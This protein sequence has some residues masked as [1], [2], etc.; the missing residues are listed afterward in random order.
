MNPAEKLRLDY[1]IRLREAPSNKL[2]GQYARWEASQGRVEAAC[3]I[4]ERYLDSTADPSE[5]IWLLYTELSPSHSMKLDILT[6]AIHQQPLS[7]RL[8]RS[9]LK[10]FFSPDGAPLL[11]ITNMEHLVKSWMNRVLENGS[12]GHLEALFKTLVDI[13][14]QLVYSD[15]VQ[16]Y[17]ELMLLLLHAYA[18]IPVAKNPLLFAFNTLQQLIKRSK[19]D[20]RKLFINAL[21]IFVLVF[22][23]ISS[24]S[25][26][27]SALHRLYLLYE[28]MKPHFHSL[29]F[30]D[31]LVSSP[32]NGTDESP[33]TSIYAFLHTARANLETTS[34][35]SVTELCLLLAYDSLLTLQVDDR[36]S[37]S[38]CC[39]IF[40]IMN[41]AQP[42][43]ESWSDKLCV[44]QVII[45]SEV[46][47][48][49][50]AAVTEVLKSLVLSRDN[51]SHQST[52][53]S[54]EQ[55]VRL[56]SSIQYLLQRFSSEPEASKCVEYLLSIF[57]PTALSN[58]NQ[59]FG[60]VEGL[61]QMLLTFPKCTQFTDKILSIIEKV[62]PIFFDPHTIRLLL[63]ALASRILAIENLSDAALARIVSCSISNGETTMVIDVMVL[64]RN[65]QSCFELFQSIT[66]IIFNNTKAKGAFS[67]AIRCLTE[68]TSVLLSDT[69]FR[70]D[71]INFSLN[72]ILDLS[73][74][75]VKDFLDCSSIILL[76][77]LACMT[78]QLTEGHIFDDMI[79][80]D[81]IESVLKQVEIVH[82]GLKIGEIFLIDQYA[83]LSSLIGTVFEYHEL[84]TGIETI[85]GRVALECV[86]IVKDKEQSR[87]LL[88]YELVPVD[89]SDGDGLLKLLDRI[90]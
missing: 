29:F 82:I 59:L 1:E 88:L 51:H 42:F 43:G 37:Q 80:E 45:E 79:F 17:E 62:D 81:V 87:S 85:S 63:K 2:W 38:S 10:F 8:H 72:A 23:T 31:T 53:L 24:F 86:V 32:V 16:Q 26:Q 70:N 15:S 36:I 21:K 49:R 69:E 34:S 61:L 47:V 6:R 28:F 14:E 74:M 13:L 4:C 12:P 48:L 5:D 66:R 40:A 22:P 76:L 75:S 52:G 11:S 83:K 3:V 78:Q 68:I 18:S 65:K 56:Y 35:M 9:I 7:T 46:F 20:K 27:Y 25:E 39:S 84:I 30:A 90:G 67:T 77:F 55:L 44:L 41:P 33:L 19:L 60:L 50:K 58:F 57:L 71:S 89:R 73:H 54:D 64:A